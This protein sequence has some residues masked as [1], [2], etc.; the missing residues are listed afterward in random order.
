MNKV[1][2]SGLLVAASFG[3]MNAQTVHIPDAAFK[4]KLL[5]HYPKIDT[6]NDNEI[7]VAEA[8]AVIDN[9][10][11]S[12]GGIQDLTGLEAFKNIKTLRIEGNSITSGT[13]NLQAQKDLQQL[14][15]EDCSLSSIDLSQN[16]DLEI[17]NCNIN[18]ISTLDVSH[19]P[20]LRILE[21][22]EN[23]L[24]ALDLN[25]NPQLT[26]LMC[27]YNQ[28]SALDLSQNKDLTDISAYDNQISAL[29]ISQNTALVRID[30]EN[31]QLT[32]LDASQ[33]AN[34][35]KLILK[36]NQLNSLDISFGDYQ[37]FSELD[38]T[39]N[40]A[41][42]CVKITAGQ[43][44]QSTWMKDDSASFNANCGTMGVQNLHTINETAVFPNPTTDLVKVKSVLT[45]TSIKV[46]DSAG[47]LVAQNQNQQNI[48]LKNLNRG[49]YILHIT[50]NGENIIKKV[51]KK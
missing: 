10:S 47:H 42:S 37:N 25:Q 4:S 51:I 28:I 16:A 13:L 35:L 32:T 27:Y 6:D 11:L 34:L 2:F 29:D 9:L 18:Q 43:T 40:P 33:N 3:I 17:L 12:D 19:N 5:T 26:E 21:C 24:T 45:P 31:N 14:Y 49:V 39:N 48:S 20:K 44:P 7:S 41:L 46:Y 23:Q 1:L 50:I 22:G 30:L 38:I 15:A 36:N 8:E